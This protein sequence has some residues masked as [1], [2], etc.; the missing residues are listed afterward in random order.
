[1]KK[2]EELAR[3][4]RTPVTVVKGAGH[5]NEKVGY[6]KFELLLKKILETIRVS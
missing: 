4:L 6:V 2:A 1:M 5:F 3:N